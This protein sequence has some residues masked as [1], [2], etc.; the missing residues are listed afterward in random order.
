MTWAHTHTH[1]HRC[2]SVKHFIIAWISKFLTFRITNAD[3]GI[4]LTLN[5][6]CTFCINGFDIC[7]FTS[8]GLY[9]WK[10]WQRF[11]FS[12]SLEKFA[13]T[14]V[15]MMRQFHLQR[16][17]FCFFRVWVYYFLWDYSQTCLNHNFI[18]KPVTFIADNCYSGYI[19]LTR[20]KRSTQVFLFIAGTT[21]FLWESK[22]KPLF[23]FQ[24][25]GIWHAS[26]LLHLMIY[27]IPYCIKRIKLRKN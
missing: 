14:L 26:L 12:E 17:L 18:E 19:F 6:L 2:K 20:M 5:Y 25:L 22:N 3:K 23:E 27:L 11:L 24:I 16:K 13:I 10:Y 9:L 7:L 21:N 4:A 15:L 1:T 8:F